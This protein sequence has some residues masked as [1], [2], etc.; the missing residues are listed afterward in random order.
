MVIEWPVSVILLLRASCYHLCIVTALRP[1]SFSSSSI[2]QVSKF[3]FL[4]TTGAGGES[5]PCT[6]PI[7]DETIE[8]PIRVEVGI[9]GAMTEQRDLH[10]GNSVERSSTIGALPNIPSRAAIE[11]LFDGLAEGVEDESGQN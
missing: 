3:R 8:S 5:N 11:G 4:E 9:D 10:V 7:F 2:Y 1:A 6:D